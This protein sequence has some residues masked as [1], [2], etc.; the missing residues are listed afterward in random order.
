MFK[1]YLFFLQFFII[2]KVSYSGDIYNFEEYFE[3]GWK[4]V[5]LVFVVD[6]ENFVDF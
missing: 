1:I 3:D 5:F 6:F 2:F 4:D